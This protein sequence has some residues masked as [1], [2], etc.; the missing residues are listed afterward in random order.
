MV[1][2]ALR[3]ELSRWASSGRELSLRVNPGKVVYEWVHE[4]RDRE[5]ILAEYDVPLIIPMALSED[6]FPPMSVIVFGTSPLELG[7]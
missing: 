5:A 7:V 6:N 3:K 2:L 1:R 4:T